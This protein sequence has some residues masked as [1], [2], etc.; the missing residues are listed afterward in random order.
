M[1]VIYDHNNV[2]FSK[3]FIN[4]LMIIKKLKTPFL[5]LPNDCSIENLKH[6]ITTIEYT[7]KSKDRIM[8]ANYL[9]RKLSSSIR[10]IFPT[11][12]DTGILSNIKDNIYFA[13]KLLKK[14]QNNY[15]FQETGNQSEKLITDSIKLAEIKKNATIILST[16]NINMLP[17]IFKPFEIKIINICR[18]NPVLFIPPNEDFLIPCH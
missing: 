7:K 6:I 11:E 16:D 8:W 9:G 15:T 18:K 3:N 13:E 12:K 14:S 17:H 2:K 10:L 4:I 1:L 5:I